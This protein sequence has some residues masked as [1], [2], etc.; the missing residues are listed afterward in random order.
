MIVG[1]LT[2]RAV[3]R[4]AR[5]LKDKRHVLKSFTDRLRNK[6]NVAVA[7]VDDADEWQSADLGVTTVA[8][9]SR[10]VNSV[11]SG[12][13]DFARGCPGMELVDHQIEIFNC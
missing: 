2:L 11:L 8:N 5:S 9:D 4:E 1:A 3:F 6:F 7:E 10:F 13:L 12:V